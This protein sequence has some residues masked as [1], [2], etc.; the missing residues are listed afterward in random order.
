MPDVDRGGLISKNILAFASGIHKDQKQTQCDSGPLDRLCSRD[1]QF[2]SQS[3]FIK[4]RKIP[5]PSAVTSKFSGQ[6]LHRCD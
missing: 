1:L 4:T 5:L 6:G 3:D 2:L